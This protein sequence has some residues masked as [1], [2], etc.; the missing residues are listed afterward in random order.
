MIQ[1]NY[2]RFKARR[3]FQMFLRIRVQENERRKRMERLKR[4]Q[5]IKALLASERLHSNSSVLRP[6]SLKAKQCLIL[7][8]KMA[9]IKRKGSKKK[10]KPE[11]AENSF[12][13]IKTLPR[14]STQEG[15]KL[16]KASPKETSGIL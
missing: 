11:K 14:A 12:E 5:E 13:E 10:C 3:K 4:E 1:R 16:K 9:K 15:K 7:E 8:T 6:P 2:L